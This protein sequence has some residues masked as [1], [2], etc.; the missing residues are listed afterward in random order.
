M[1][2]RLTIPCWKL[3]FRGCPLLSLGMCGTLLRNFHGLTLKLTRCSG[4]TLIIMIGVFNMQGCGTILKVYGMSASPFSCSQ[5]H[6]G[7]RKYVSH[8]KCQR[9]HCGSHKTCQA[10]RLPAECYGRLP[11]TFPVVAPSATASSLLQIFQA[12]R[13]FQFDTG[14]CVVG[15]HS[16]SQRFW[17][18]F[19]RL[20]VGL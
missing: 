17:L 10:R 1:M 8:E 14:S 11:E 9:G 16:S 6:A 2:S 3:P 18:V 19:C 20:V 13:W 12:A 4:G 15:L 5:W 7:T